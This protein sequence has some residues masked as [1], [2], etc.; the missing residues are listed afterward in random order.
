[1]AIINNDVVKEIKAILED[2]I[3]QIGKKPYHPA[4]KRLIIGGK[5]TK[6]ALAYNRKLLNEGKTFKYLDQRKRY[7]PK[8]KRLYEPK[9]DKRFKKLTFTK[10]FKNENVVGQVKKFDT[11]DNKANQ[12]DIVILDKELRKR[13][14]EIKKLILD[15]DVNVEGQPIR[16]DLRKYSLEQ[17]LNLVSM[18][19]Q[20]S[21]KTKDGQL[22]GY[23]KIITQAEGS[24]RWITLSQTNIGKLKSYQDIMGSSYKD[25]IGSDNEYIMDL[26]QTPFIIIKY[27]GFQN[28]NQKPQGA[29]FKYYHK[30]DG[31]DFSSLGIYYDKPKNYKHNCFYNALKDQGLNDDKLNMLK[32]LIFS[33]NKQE[34]FVFSSYVPTC[35]LNDIC[36]KL[37][38]GIDLMR[39]KNNKKSCSKTINYGKQYDKRY[40]IGLVD[41]HYFSIK[42]LNITSCAVKNFEDIK[43]IEN[44][45]KLIKKNGKYEKSNKNFINSF[46]FVKLL[47]ENKDKVLRPIPINDIMHS[48]YYKKID[49]DENETLEY[50]ESCIAENEVSKCDRTNYYTIFYDFET[51]TTTTTHTPYLMQYITQDDEKGGFY[52][53]ESGEA[54]INYIKNKFRNEEADEKGKI[55]DVLLI[56]HN[57]RY[58]FTFIL[59]HLYA[60]NPILKGNRLMGGNARIYV[61][62]KTY[63]NVEFQDTLNFLNCK[64][65]DFKDMFKLDVKKEI[66][67]YSLYNTD[68]I[69]NKYIKLNECLKHV[70]NNEINEYINN[71]KN[72]GCIDNNEDVNIIEYSRQYCIMDC[73]V[74]KQ[75]YEIFK[76]WMD[77]A[78]GLNIKNYCSIASM[79]QDYLINEGCYNGC[80]KISG[81][82]RDFIQKSLVG[83]RCM[84]KQN[85]KW[86]VKGKINDFDA[87][88]LYP[89][90]MHRMA[91]FLKGKPKVLK[92]LNIEWL[93]NNSDGYFI[94]VLCLNNPSI[95]RDFPLLSKIK[96]DGIRDFT[97]ETKGEIFYLDKTAYEDA[98]KYQ[99]LDFKIISGYYYDEGR[100]NKINKVIEHLFDKRLEKK[101]E[102]NPIEKVYKL[103]MNSCYGKSMLKPIEDDIK[104]IPKTQFNNYLGRNYN[105]IKEYTELE[106]VNI[107]K[108]TK[109]IIEHF[110]NCYAGVEILSMSKRIMNEVMTTAEDAGLNIYYQDTDSMHINDVDIS[111]LEKLYNEKYG[112][113]LIGKKMG[114]FHSDFELGKCKNVYAVESIFL[115]KKSYYDKL[116]GF[117]DDNEI[118]EGEHIR[119]KGIPN[120]SIKYYAE[121]NN[122]TVGD[123][124]NM[125]YENNK[126]K[127][128]DKFDLLAGGQLCRFTYNKNMSV[129]TCTE[130]ART[131]SFNYVK[132]N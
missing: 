60:L 1:M 56:A 127:N 68:N 21:V 62:N 14:N 20:G 65:S 25:R 63:I 113:E 94:K 18:N 109:P 40:K 57:Q 32:S 80:Y 30:F 7:N 104:V 92:N 4:P 99:G 96:D 44:Y 54:F 31:L 27:L 59:N 102:E 125:L 41:E 95:I 83:G 126:L 11:F 122:I 90:A 111:K 42:E 16:I 15:N 119:M 71:C 48:Q 55:K 33:K 5:P 132:G 75:G 106:K 39:V 50:N 34:T 114:Q 74:L 123:I 3:K 9:I 98:V 117:N 58:D 53:E 76:R 116:N 29:F 115:G 51:D 17:V 23:I 121:H 105:F 24:G 19:M 8:T 78:T 128:D 81:V 108:E 118:E 28:K 88:S 120:A 86:R 35:K 13:N 22:K 46:M 64:L 100:N 69:N 37:E 10:K 72:W 38:I 103:M 87:V 26:I 67:P 77:E 79:G 84:T 82:V 66:M 43:H 45:N 97:N 89:S 91:G 52:G 85:K 73:E 130:F 93:Q 131:V 2:E 112:R 6:K 110:N 129:K 70:K 49:D 124:Y 101:K 47:I 61:S 107:V 12:S 36:D